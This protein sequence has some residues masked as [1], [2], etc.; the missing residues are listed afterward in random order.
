V[1]EWLAP[2]RAA[3]A[4]LL[5]GADADRVSLTQI[6]ESFRQHRALEKSDAVVLDWDAALVVDLAGRPDDVLFTIE[7]AN[8]Q[9]EEFR[10]MDRALDRFL[11]RAYDDLERRSLRFFGVSS[12][13]LG[14]LRR[15][16]IDLAKL[17]DEVTNITK[18]FGDWHLARVYLAARERFHIDQ[19]KASVEGR[20]SQLDQLYNLV[21]TESFERRTLL[22]EVLVAVL[23]VLELI[24][25]FR[26]TH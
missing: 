3:V 26:G 20:L 22:L 13:V 17:A 16:R 6:D 25:S 5:V 24:N 1:G 23:I 8:V 14:K 9:L 11:N 19:W 7:L 2:N 15:F 10:Q 12:A 18:F 21:H 4:G